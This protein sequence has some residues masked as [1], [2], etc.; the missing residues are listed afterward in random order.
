MSRKNLNLSFPQNNQ[1]NSKKNIMKL[2]GSLIPTRG[3]V[4]DP[5]KA[6]EIAKKLKAQEDAK[7]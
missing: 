6:I 5:D 1:V 2:Y 7:L 3:K 4:I